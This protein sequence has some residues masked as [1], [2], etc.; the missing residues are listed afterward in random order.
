[1]RISLENF[2]TLSIVFAL[3]LLVRA[4]Y[5]VGIYFGVG[6]EGL[7][8]EDS[9]IY[10]A[11][12]QTFLETG[13]FQREIADN[14][15]IPETERMPLYIFFL[16]I[17][18]GISGSIDPLFPALTQCFLGA[19]TCLMIYQMAGL[20]DKRLSLLA[21]IFSAFNPTMII[22]GTSILTDGLFFFLTTASLWAAMLWL[23]GPS[24][25]YAIFLGCILAL[26][27]STRVMI[28]PWA[29][30]CL[31]LL[32]LGSLL[33]SKFKFSQLG[34]MLFIALIVIA[35]QSPIL[36]RN[37][38]QFNS[39]QLTSQGG[40][41]T[42]NWVVPLVMEVND[43]TPQVEGAKVM[44]KRFDEQFGSQ[45]INNPFE[46][47]N[48]M[49]ALAWSEMAKLDTSAILKSWLLGSAINLFS[50]SPI[51]T[52]PI[53]NLPRTGFFDTPGD[54]KIEKIKSFLFNNDSMIYAWVLLI[55]LVFLFITR[56]VQLIGFIVLIK[57][58]WVDKTKRLFST[59]RV[60]LLFLIIWTV[61]ILLLNGPI[62]SPKYRI[63][64]EPFFGIT[65]A[66]AIVTITIWWG[67]KKKLS[68]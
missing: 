4:A 57:D 29:G 11:L 9:P 13:D 16:A 60:Q 51:L 54:S 52:P 65:F 64:I 41:H 27:I 23:K 22:I 56:A 63:P 30:A 25:K 39:W 42:L 21:G 68:R 32:P 20:I 38:Q 3:A 15:Y 47:S 31:I 37:I 55:S 59:G 19:L 24:L 67:Q 2:S 35:S 36:I 45:Q 62:A 61:Y 46:K 1:L 34:H 48:K 8:Y 58:N 26:A 14:I 18:Q 44:T 66:A 10:V 40:T 53:K 6:I 49:Q 5:T 17:H 7:F 43:G 12:A 28:L 33:I 50:P